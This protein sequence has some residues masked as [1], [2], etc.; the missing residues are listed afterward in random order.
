M[1]QRN[2]YN[3]IISIIN[4]SLS[5][6][7][8]TLGVIFKALKGDTLGI[9]FTSIIYA[10]LITNYIFKAIF[11]FKNESTSK[12]VFYRLSKITTDIYS[13]LISIY[14]ILLLDNNLKWVLFG[15]ICAILIS[16]ILL[17][18][19]DK[20]TEIRYLLFAIVYFIVIFN[21]LSLYT[22]DI[23]VGMS[24]LSLLIDYI[25]NFLGRIT[26][27]KIILSFELISVIMFGLFFLTV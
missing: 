18:A 23:L 25:S 22:L 11:Y 16:E 27:N 21:I 2:L 8:L 1:K 10:I 3:M 20:L 7:F 24:I 12:K 26:N 14:F 13:C 15:L 5:L 17:D 6:V 9:I 19:F 4:S